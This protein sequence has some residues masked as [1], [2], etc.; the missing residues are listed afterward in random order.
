[1]TGILF[2]RTTGV[3]P[4]CDVVS[5]EAFKRLL[6]ETS[7]VEGIVGYKL[8]CI[9]TLTYGLPALVAAAKEITDLPL[10]YD[11]QKAATDIPDVAKGFAEVCARAGIGAA[12][13]F[14]QAGPET[15]AAFAAALLERNLVPIVGGEMTHPKYLA[16]EGGF[17]RDEAPREMYELGAELGVTHFVIPGNRPESIERYSRTLSGIVASP[18]FLMP[19]IG[20]QGGDVSSAFRAAGPNSCYAIIGSGIYRAADVRK[21]TERLCSEAL[22]FER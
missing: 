14:P 11:H 8:G 18:K 10:I 19:G 6:D 1:M 17:I 16:K 3:V 21:A 4:A 12:I 9:L 13:I 15:G 2:G 20:R 5:L 7:S 22:E